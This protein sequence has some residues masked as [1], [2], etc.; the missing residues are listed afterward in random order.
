MQCDHENKDPHVFVYCFGA[1]ERT[2]CDCLFIN[3]FLTGVNWGWGGG[4]AILWVTH[5][6]YDKDSA[7]PKL[8]SLYELRADPEASCILI[9]HVHA[10]TRYPFCA[11]MSD[12]KHYIDLFE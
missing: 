11:Y 1:G 8:L 2:T 10:C 5:C 6:P 9:V 3:Y 12:H 7:W 4:V